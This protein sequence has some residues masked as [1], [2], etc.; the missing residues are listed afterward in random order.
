M[1]L[2]VPWLLLFAVAEPGIPERFLW[3]LPL[4]VLV[5]AAFVTVLLPRI[6]V[7]RPAAWLAQGLLVFV[8]LWNS[9]LV[10]R[11]DAWRADGWAGHDAAEVRVVDY[12]AA[13]ISKRGRDRASIG[14]RLFIYPFMVDYHTVNPYYKVGTEFDV[15][16]KYQHGI[17]NT[18]RCAEGVSSGDDYRIVQTRPKK[19]QDAPITYFKVPLENRFRLVREIGMYR[20]FKATREG[21]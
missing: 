6:G 13:D 1:A 21:T 3:L 20:I 7:P 11:V 14:Y 16:F 18:D 17:E 10:S 15:L 8:F 4:H 5:L 12:I 19:A 9:F 2:A